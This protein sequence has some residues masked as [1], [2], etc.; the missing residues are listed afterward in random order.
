MS[1]VGVIDL[2]SFVSYTVIESCGD[3]V[4]TNT[5]HRF[6]RW[7]IG[8]FRRRVILYDNPPRPDFLGWLIC[9]THSAVHAGAPEAVLV[10]WL[11]WAPRWRS[12]HL[13]SFIPPP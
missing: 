6:A 5:C 1:E 4:V 13:T 10:I 9:E 8:Q 12:E 2:I 7:L 11:P 3:C